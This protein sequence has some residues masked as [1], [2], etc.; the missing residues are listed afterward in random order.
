MT[1]RRIIIIIS[2]ALELRYIDHNG[3]GDAQREETE[4]EK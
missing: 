1:G 3:K 2:L 4:T